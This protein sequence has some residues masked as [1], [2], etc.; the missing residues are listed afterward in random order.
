VGTPS[1]AQPGT[2]A[3]Q[4][5]RFRW[6]T[7]I[8]DWLLA[9]W[10]ALVAPTVVH[11]QA[12]SGGVFDGGRPLDGLFGLVGILG[13]AVCLA[14]GS[15]GDQHEGFAASAVIGPFSG[16]F[17]LVAIS[18][19]SALGLPQAAAVA[20]AVV[21]IAVALATRLRYPVLPAR[22]RRA[23]VTPYVLV[24]GGLFWSLIG[25]VT[26]GGTVAAV[27]DAVPAD[28]QGALPVAGFL[29]AFSAIYYAMLVFAPR[30][31]AEREGGPVAWIV[32]YLLFAV[33][34]A[35]GAGWLLFLAG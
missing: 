14:T 15:D 32:R 26:G 9:A 25:A 3:A 13:V 27:R 10:V 4:P 21:V 11:I 12:G 29:I 18:T 28:P 30:Q 23:L 1:V 16:G 6:R 20:V 7:R 24:T 5:P 33:S 8:E 2:A 17:L 31:V 19:V 22:V 34:I 35:F